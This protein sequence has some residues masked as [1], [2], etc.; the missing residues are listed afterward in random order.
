MTRRMA[1]R[2]LIVAYL[3]QANAERSTHRITI[4]M[5]MKHH[6]NPSQ[7]TQALTSCV[8]AGQIAR[9]SRGIY[10]AETTQRVDCTD[11]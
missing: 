8:K 11:E 2:D 7:V 5:F 4:F 1:I 9:V 6:V 3:V 10:R